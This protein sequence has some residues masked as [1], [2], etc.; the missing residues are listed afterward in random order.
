[1]VRMNLTCADPSEYCGNYKANV[2][3][4]AANEWSMAGFRYLHSFVPNWIDLY[5]NC[6]FAF[7]KVF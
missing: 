1:M 6:K 2:N 5:R 3:P 4:M 7:T